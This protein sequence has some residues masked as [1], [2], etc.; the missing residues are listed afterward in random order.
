VVRVEPVSLPAA[1]APVVGAPPGGSLTWLRKGGSTC[2]AS[3]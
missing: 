2:W 1:A 3:L